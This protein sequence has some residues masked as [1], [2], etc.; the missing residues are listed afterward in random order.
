MARLS[1][2]VAQAIDVDVRS[3]ERAGVPQAFFDRMID[4]L[5]TWAASAPGTRQFEQLIKQNGTD[6]KI[7][8]RHGS[9]PELFAAALSPLWYRPDQNDIAVNYNQVR[10]YE[11]NPDFSRLAIGAPFHF[12]SVLAHELD[13]ANRRETFSPLQAAQTSEYTAIKTRVLG[14]ERAIARTENV[15]RKIF[16]QPLRPVQYGE[17]IE[18]LLEGL[19]NK[20][21]RHAAEPIKNLGRFL[22]ERTDEELKAYVGIHVMSERGIHQVPGLNASVVGHGYT[23]EQFNRDVSR[24]IQNIRETYLEAARRHGIEPNPGAARQPSSPARALPSAR[25]DD[26]SHDR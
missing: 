17:D 10:F 14:E 11:N 16:G 21:T 19:K 6:D 1:P 13:H 15:A 9:S 23:E 24:E 18:S 20:P 26:R 2:L 8:L 7:T 25:N 5:N 12:G 3:F 22:A 4:D